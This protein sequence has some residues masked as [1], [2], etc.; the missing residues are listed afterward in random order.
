MKD[1]G[2]DLDC[3]HGNKRKNL[4]LLK[5]L[6]NSSSS[7]SNNNYYYYCYYHHHRFYYYYYYYCCCCCFEAGF[8]AELKVP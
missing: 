2:F 6:Y 7:S 8:V 1:S 5:Q 4:H 3:S